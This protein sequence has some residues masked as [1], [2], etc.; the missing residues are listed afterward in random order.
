MAT[1]IIPDLVKAENPDNQKL[2]NLLDGKL[3]DELKKNVGTGG[4]L[5]EFEAALD[6]L[7][8]K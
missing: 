1:E 5:A 3:W 4:G 6:K 8:N 2:A 7:I